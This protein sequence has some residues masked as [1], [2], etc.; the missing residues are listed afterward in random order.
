MKIVLDLLE[1]KECYECHRL[2]TSIR[3]VLMAT[4]IRGASNANID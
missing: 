4:Y 2:I 3:V 1:L